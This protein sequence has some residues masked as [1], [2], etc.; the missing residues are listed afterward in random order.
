MEVA[1]NLRNFIET[2]KAKT[3][4]L[5]LRSKRNDADCEPLYADDV[6]DSDDELLPM[7]EPREL[8]LLGSSS[9]LHVNKCCPWFVLNCFNIS[10]SKRKTFL[11]STSTSY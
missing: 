3:V 7:W 6:H 11:E 1:F 8:A 2:Y 9:E 5:Y 4:R 10:H